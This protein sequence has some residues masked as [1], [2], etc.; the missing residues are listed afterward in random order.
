[1]EESHCK[2]MNKRMAQM[3]THRAT[4]DAH[5]KDLADNFSPRTSR[6]ISQDRVDMQQRGDKRNHKII[7][8]SPIYAVQTL[9]AGMMSGNTS[10]AR[11]WFRL[12]TPDPQLAEFGPVKEWL[13]IAQQRMQ[14]VFARSNLY[15]VLPMIYRDLAI[16]GPSCTIAVES[17]RNVVHFIHLDIG[18][19]WL[20]QSNRQS[21]DTV[22]REFGLTVR[23]IVQ[24]FGEDNV[25]ERIRNMYRN[26]QYE[27]WEP[28]CH[29][30]EPDGDKWESIYW[31]RGA[32]DKPL[33]ERYFSTNPIL[34]PRWSLSGEDIYGESPAMTALGDARALQLKELRKQEAIDIMVKPPL[35]GPTSLRGQAAS[36]VPG[37]IT[38][39]DIQQGMQGLK[40]IHDW[41]PEI[42]P[43]LE[44]IRKT[45]DLLNQ[46]FYVNLFLM[47]ANDDRSGVTAREVSERHEEKLLMLGPVIERLNNE[48]LSPLIDRTFSIMV[49]RSLPFWQGNID[50]DPLLPPPPEELAG[51][52]LKVE[53]VSIMAQAQKAVGIGAMDNLMNFVGAIAALKPEALDKVDFDQAIDERADMLGISPRIIVP[54]DAVV[55]LREQRAKA[56]QA[57]QMA[58]AAQ[59][60]GSV[61]KDLSQADMSGD[62]ALTRAMDLAGGG[63]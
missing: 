28:V 34:A 10:P 6:Y 4:Y 30:I 13:H 21:V 35:M 52:D 12:T 41:R 31:E 19:Y 20:A 57:Q 44:D 8:S 37:D 50:G 59:T 51:L 38:Y 46:A 62:S 61:A 27:T 53:F 18:S 54:D 47:L 23:Q 29:A 39:V 32:T 42:A 26:G 14:E 16:W 24:E 58:A 25:S 49:E 22:Y 33:G 36:L 7:N 5:W 15:R 11:P 1:M 45:E 2:R 40:P 43:L 9:S 17:D 56:M 3:K 48:L 60:A 55:S 63:R